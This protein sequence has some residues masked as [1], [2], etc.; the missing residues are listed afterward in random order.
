LELRSALVVEG[1]AG[2]GKSTIWHAITE[3]AERR[4]FR[5]LRARPAQTETQLALSSVADLF[6][7]VP[8]SASA[9][10]PAPQRHT[11]DVALLRAEP[12]TDA[13]RRRTLAAGAV[14]RAR[15][16][17]ADTAGLFLA[18]GRRRSRPRRVDVGHRARRRA[19]A[20]AARAGVCLPTIHADGSARTL[21]TMRTAFTHAELEA[22]RTTGHTR[23]LDETIA[24]AA[25]VGH[26]HIHDRSRAAPDPR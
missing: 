23:P 11:L 9:A 8:A 20:I 5:V 17:L 21:A 19:G 1:D 7:G 4:G 2:V 3:L 15:A 18:I 12:G 26:R 24:R 14:G 13:L 6:D 22:A 16:P 25:D 10:L